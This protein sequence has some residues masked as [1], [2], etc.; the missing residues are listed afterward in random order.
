[1]DE[2]SVRVAAV[3]EGVLK[4]RVQGQGGQGRGRNDVLHVIM[5]DVYQAARVRRMMEERSDGEEKKIF[6]DERR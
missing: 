2:I 1:M 4:L 3:L 6:H 5:S